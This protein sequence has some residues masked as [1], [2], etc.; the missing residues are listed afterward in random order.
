[1]TS[2]FLNLKETAQYLKISTSLVYK[3]VAKKKIPFRKIG[4]KLLFPIAEL[5]SW[6]AGQNDT[7]FRTQS[8][9]RTLQSARVSGSLKSRNLGKAG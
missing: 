8:H 1:M 6:I 3:M 5:D 2:P 9:F 7:L 4:A